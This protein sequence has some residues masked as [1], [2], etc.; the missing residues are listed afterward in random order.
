M[1]RRA[2]ESVLRQTYTDFE[3]IVVDDGS[4]DNTRE[5]LSAL[6]EKVRCLFL[7]HKG[8]SC[9]RNR[10]LSIANG[11][12]IAFLDSDD[13]F[14]PYTLEEQ[15]NHLKKNPEFGM[16]YG[17]AVCF[18]ERGDFLGTYEAK[19][20][21]WLYDDVAF[22]RPITITL[23]TVM[24]RRGVIEE[25]GGFDEELERFEDTDM[26]RRVSRRYKILAIEKPLSKLLTHE[27]NQL[28]DPVLELQRIRQYIRKVFKEDRGVLSISK[29]KRAAN[30][31][32]HYTHEVYC[33]PVYPRAV[34]RFAFWT[35][36][37]WPFNLVYYKYFLPRD[38]KEQI[39][40]KFRSTYR[41][42]LAICSFYASALYF[43]FHLLF[44]DPKEFRS[45]LKRRMQKQGSFHK[46]SRTF[47]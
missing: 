1:V 25:I 31:L 34:V 47:I 41:R 46:R 6:S 12:Y 11:S 13:V 28:Q 2:V 33:S 45:R 8:R 24:I 10:A 16:V 5:I 9:A 22:Y 37:Y 15:V 17:S 38:I 14:L 44:T 26:W 21:G 42:C 32:H 40:D 19:K 7:P 23:P 20:S 4:T 27:G 30:L 43:P 35:V 36:F 18:N 29:R 3:V 39:K